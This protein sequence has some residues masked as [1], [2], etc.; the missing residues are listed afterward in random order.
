MIISHFANQ[1]LHLTTE[2]PTIG[3]MSSL[4]IKTKLVCGPMFNATS[5]AHQTGK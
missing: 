2:V 5:E 3:L 1:I 4:R